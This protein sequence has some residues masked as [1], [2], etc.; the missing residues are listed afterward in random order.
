MLDS[1]VTRP[2]QAQPKRTQPQTGV[3]DSALFLGVGAASATELG[4]SA[5][6]ICCDARPWLLIDCGH[7]T[8]AR[9]K[10]AFGSQSL[11]RA[12]FITHLHYDHIGGLEQ[13]YFKAALSGQTVRLYVPVQLIQSLFA[14]LAYTGLA[15]RRE[16]VWHTFEL[17]PVGEQFFHQQLRLNCYPVRHQAPGSAFSLHLPGRFFYS[18]DTRPIPELL[19]HQVTQGEIIFHDCVASANPSHAGLDELLK[20]YPPAVLARLCVYHYHGADDIHAFEQAGI[21]YAEPQQLISLC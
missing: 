17:H 6:V 8:L 21:R 3:P 13:L 18:G 10:R 9:Y 19:I 12:V 20:E 15:E 7:D 16:D 4:N 14:M 2:A 5:C 11:P 1:I